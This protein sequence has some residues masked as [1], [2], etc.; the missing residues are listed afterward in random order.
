MA[1]CSFRDKLLQKTAGTDLRRGRVY[2]VTKNY[3]WSKSAKLK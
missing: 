3:N 1:I 2:P